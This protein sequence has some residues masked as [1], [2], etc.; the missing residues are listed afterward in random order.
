MRAAWALPM[1]LL[2]G[3]A[4]ETPPAPA[5]TQAAALPHASWAPG[6]WWAY[7]AAYAGHVVD[8][9]LI[10]HAA[11]PEGYRLGSNLSAGLF[12][13]PWAGEVTLE[14]NPRIGGEVWP[15]FTFPLEPGKTWDYSLFGHAAKSVVRAQAEDGYALEASSFGQTFARY[16][17]A[18]DAGWFTRLTL[19]EPTN[20]TTMLDA[21]LVAAGTDWSA[22]YYVEETLVERRVENPGL[23]GALEL[24]LPGGFAHVR[25][26]LRSTTEAGAVFAELRDAD[27]RVLVASR[28][29]ARGSD[30]ARVTLREPDE[31]VWTLVH[32]GA[33]VG[34][35]E[36]LVTGIAARGPLADAPAEGPAFDLA[37][38][39]Q[40]TRPERPHAGHVIRTGTPVG[41]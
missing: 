6:S 8:V 32:H 12:G 19:V 5:T 10:V 13:L 34:R 16:D 37:S 25:A 39:L 35:V 7:Q 27:G 22:A 11:T 17:Y 33:G 21:R 30:L 3:C 9:A 26:E 28:A 31:G 15:L 18:H 38:L 4:A 36:L 14:R 24:P 41:S 2:A 1:L 23:P 40:S 29:L 20:G